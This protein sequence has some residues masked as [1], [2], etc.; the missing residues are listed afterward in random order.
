MFKSNKIYIKY[1]KIDWNVYFL[2]L[3]NYLA[4][5]N[6]QTVTNG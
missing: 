5:F 4:D 1:Y 2:V 3:R 6:L